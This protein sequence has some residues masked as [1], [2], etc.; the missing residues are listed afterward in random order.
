MSLQEKKTIIKKNTDR[1]I[2]I[3]V[4]GVLVYKVSLTYIILLNAPY[5]NV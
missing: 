2:M 5:N 3:K 4:F 1:A